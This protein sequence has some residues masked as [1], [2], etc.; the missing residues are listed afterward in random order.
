MPAALPVDWGVIAVQAA[1]GATLEELSEHYGLSINTLKTRSAREGWKATARQIQAE[2]T[3][4]EVVCPQ[5]QSV[6]PR[7]TN[8]GLS[9]MQKIG[10]RSKLRLARTV[11]RTAKVLHKQPDPDLV[12]NTQ[13]LVN[14]VNAASKLHNWQPSNTQP[15]V[16][17][18]L[19]N[20][21]LPDAP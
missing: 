14:T 17:I 1:A 19:A 7:E 21:K 8:H 9:L 6:K 15:L 11:D 16:N 10:D 12:R 2:K 4:T 18:N 3:G 20:V 5:H 13:A